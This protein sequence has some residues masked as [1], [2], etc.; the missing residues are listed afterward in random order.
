MHVATFERL[1][2]YTSVLE[3]KLPVYRYCVAARSLHRDLVGLVFMN[4]HVPADTTQ[5]IGNSTL[6]CRQQGTNDQRLWPISIAGVTSMLLLSGFPD[7]ARKCTHYN[8]RTSR[9]CQH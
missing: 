9:H 5:R 1:A 7:K 3:L 2:S 8:W 4:H 6:P